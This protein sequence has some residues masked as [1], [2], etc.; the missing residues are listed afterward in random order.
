MISSHIQLSKQIITISA[1]SQ[2]LF[3]SSQPV[4]NSSSKF[5]P[6]LDIEPINIVPVL[7]SPP[8]SFVLPCRSYRVRHGLTCQDFKLLRPAIFASCTDRLVLPIGVGYDE[9]CKNR[10]MYIM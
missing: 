4:Y 8:H 1:F 3:K 2:F 7:A 10:I 6:P 9:L 5:L